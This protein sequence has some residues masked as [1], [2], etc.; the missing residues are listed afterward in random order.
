MSWKKRKEGSDR[1]PTIPFKGMLRMTWKP[2]TSLPTVK[3][4]PPPTCATGW[5][6][7]LEQLGLWVAFQIQTIASIIHQSFQILAIVLNRL[8]GKAQGGFSHP[9][10]TSGAL[11][12]DATPFVTLQPCAVMS[13]YSPIHDANKGKIFGS[14]RSKPS[15]SLSFEIIQSM[16][17]S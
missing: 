15:G 1:G 17:K 16:V 3:V 8:T 12:E 4:P 7:S 5:G 10:P 11:Q 6:P 13:D 9:F 2:C 14:H